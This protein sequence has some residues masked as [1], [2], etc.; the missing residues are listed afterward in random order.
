MI[1]LS[2]KFSLSMQNLNVCIIFP[3]SKEKAILDLSPNE[4]GDLPAYSIIDNQNI[5][6]IINNDLNLDKCTRMYKVNHNSIVLNPDDSMYIS[7]T[8]GTYIQWF[9]VQCFQGSKL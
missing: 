6:D 5:C 2:N 7:L 4:S 9:Q 1:Y 8:K 3:I